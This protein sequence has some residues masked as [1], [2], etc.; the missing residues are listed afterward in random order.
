[1]N[2]VCLTLATLL[3]GGWRGE[4]VNFRYDYT[5]KSEETYAPKWEK[6]PEGWETKAGVMRGVKFVTKV[7]GDEYSYAPDRI[8]WN[9]TTNL[10]KNGS[11]VTVGQ[12]KIPANAK[13]GV[14]D[15]S[16]AGRNVK[17]RVV[18]RLLPPPK[19]WK[20]LVTGYWHHPWALARVSNTR[21]WSKEH[22]D[23]M[24]PF[25]KYTADIGL[26]TIMA[27]VCD[28]PW[29]HQCYD[30]NW[31]M[32]K[33]IKHGGKPGYGGTGEWSFDYTVFDKWV[34]FNL[35]MGVGPYI[36]CYSL[37]PWDYELWYH[38]ESGRPWHFNAKPGTK[39]YEEYWTPF[40]ID[41]RKHLKE[42]GWFDKV[43]F[44]ADER[45]PEDVKAC[46]DLLRRV[47]PDFRVAASGNGDPAVFKGFKLVGGYCQILSTIDD[48]FL[49]SAK[50]TVEN[51]GT[52][53]YYVCCAPEKPNTFINSDPD[54]SFWL[55]VYAAAKGLSGFG[56]WTFDSFPEDAMT[57]ATYACWPSGDTFFAYPNGDPS[58]RYL[59]ILNGYQNCEKWKIL[60]AEGGEI[61]AELDKLSLRYDAKSAMTKKDGDFKELI[62][63]T[64]SILNRE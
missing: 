38:D 45:S 41:F 57:D 5:S 63:D 7:H 21:P 58:W 11:C 59:G 50:K 46:M 56:R 26:R 12:I 52:V 15:L 23:F 20:T 3:L 18:N 6:A 48:K 40:L 60:K 62:A 33:H 29:N 24:R 31:T 35:E 1:M 39:E 14:Y 51:G 9:G 30:P 37:C 55:P 27:T 54:D 43:C 10:L 13:P 64:L 28:L 42:K 61:A 47:A 16:F 53:T 2:M 22:F 34:E 36:D 4:T 17:L 49:E 8:E 19:N 32:I 25:L 44:S